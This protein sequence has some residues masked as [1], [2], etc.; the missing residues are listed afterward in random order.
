MASFKMRGFDKLEKDLKRMQENARKLNGRREVPF[1][2]LFTPEFMRKHTSFSTFN[3]LLKAGGF[4]V[5]TSEDFEAIPDAEF[6]A[7]ISATTKFPS[8]EAM[9]EEAT[10]Q[11]V[12]RMLGF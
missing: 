2:D 11:Y 12:T 6:D 10:S 3:E 7:H 4:Q 1:S 9:L 5:E 8:W